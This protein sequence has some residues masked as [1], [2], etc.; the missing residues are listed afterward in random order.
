MEDSS[1][2]VKFQPEDYRGNP[3]HGG[4]NDN[5]GHRYTV[6]CGTPTTVT[7]YD[8]GTATPPP[9]FSGTDMPGSGPHTETPPCH[10]L[11]GIFR[12]ISGVWS[13]SHQTH[14]RSGTRHQ[15]G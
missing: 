5:T 4:G 7:Q 2:C 3:I 14:G 15:Y 12:Y 1:P 13:P 10:R 6:L 9:R 8:R 11:V